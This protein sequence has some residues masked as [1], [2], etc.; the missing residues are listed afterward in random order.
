MYDVIIIGAGFAGYTSAIYAIRSDLK[1]L[2]IGK[3]PGGAIVDAAEVENYP[4]YKKI[5]GFE[6]MQKFEEQAKDFGTE[7]MHKEVVDVEKKGEGFIV[8]TKDKDFETKSIIFASGTLRRE[9]EVPGAKEYKGKG[10]HMCATCDGAF[11]RDKV[12]AV[13]GGSNSA[14]HASMLL[15]RFAKKVYIIYRKEKM[16]CEPV[17]L[18]RIEA[19]DNMEIIYKNN[20]TEVKGDKFVNKIMLENE[21]NGKKELALDGVFV[22]IGSTPNSML[23][24]K[25]GVELTEAHEIIVTP[26]CETCVK[27]IFAAGDV[28]NTVLRQGITAAAQGAIAATSAYGFVTGKTTET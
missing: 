1:V 24:K 6:L 23:A 8:K 15:S 12:V 3:E 21:Y 16:R 19:K 2:L 25:L 18:D 11:Y 28:T 20:V 9:L 13:I 17:L 22:E 14:A 7:I 27:G 10:V 26:H 5:S 4:G